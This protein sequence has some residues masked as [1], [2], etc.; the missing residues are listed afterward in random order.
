M[1]DRVPGHARIPR[2]CEAALKARIGKRAPVATTALGWP[3]NADDT[4]SSPIVAVPTG[5]PSSPFVVG[6][7]PCLRHGVMAVKPQ[8]SFLACSCGWSC[9]DFD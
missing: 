5:T 4:A 3:A 8:N 2:A 6:M 7:T 1:H 9:F